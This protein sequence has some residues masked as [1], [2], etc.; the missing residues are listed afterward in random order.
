MIFV[1]NKNDWDDHMKNDDRVKW[2]QEKHEGDE[3]G[4]DD[5]S[6]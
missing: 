1:F 5:C 3:G 4:R 6:Q 2:A